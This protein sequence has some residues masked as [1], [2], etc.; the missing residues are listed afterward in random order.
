[1]DGAVGRVAMHPV[2]AGAADYEGSLVRRRDVTGR[3]DADAPWNRARL[4]VDEDR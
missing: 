3:G 2:V 1:V 4:T